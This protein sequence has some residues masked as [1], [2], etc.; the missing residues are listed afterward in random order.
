M[1]HCGQY[2]LR[3]PVP[4]P[5]ARWRRWSVGARNE[6]VVTFRLLLH[7]RYAYCSRVRS[8]ACAGIPFRGEEKV[9]RSS[10]PPPAAYYVNVWGCSGR[11]S[12]SLASFILSCSR[13]KPRE[14]A[15]DVSQRMIS[16]DGL[17]SEAAHDTSMQ[18]RSTGP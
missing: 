6:H 17:G 10:P 9:R 15:S 13:L 2:T 1:E 12:R 8:L 4:S 14:H 7:R 11:D 3:G 18:Y 16:L 5:A